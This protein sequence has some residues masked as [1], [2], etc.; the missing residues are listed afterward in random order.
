[1]NSTSAIDNVKLKWFYGICFGFLAMLC[2]GIM[3]ENYWIAALPLILG[4]VYLSVF[5]ID[6]LMFIVVFAT[7]LAINL[8]E[9]GFGT[10]LSVPSEPLM[11]G[12]M[13]LFLLKIMFEGGFDRRVLY[14]PV[15]IAIIINLLWIFITSL[16]STMIIVSLKHLMA[17]CWFV[18]TFYFLGTQLFREYKNI[19]RFIWVYVIP[20]IIVIGYTIIRHAGFSFTETTAHW[21][22]YPFYNDH[23]AYAAAIAMF[24]PVMIGLTRN[25]NYSLNKRM[26]SLLVCF[27][28]TIAIVLSYTRAAWISLA[29]ALIVYL[30]F[31]F[32]I[33]FITVFISFTGLLILFF[34]FRSQV[35]MK[36]EKNRHHSSTDFNSHLQSISN[37]TTDASNLERINRWNSALRMFEQKPFFGWGPGTYQFKYA[38]YQHSDEMTII[39][40][41]A[42]DRGNSHSEYIGPLAESGV[43]GAL[44]F[45]LIVVVVI[46]RGSM[47]Y[48]RSKDKE[49]RLITLG[50]VL[51]LVTYFVHGALNNF[52]DTDKASVP[53]WGFIGILTA[54]D[55]YHSKRQQDARTNGE[56]N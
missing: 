16:T 53:F 29:V 27:I 42:G 6:A 30:I 2:I 31:A 12:I 15:T 37:I 9:K 34:A 52:L 22:M 38:P 50:I 36:L 23:T 48:I 40:T 21:V 47:L 13:I 56:Q 3:K 14:H 10:S 41:N 35:T 5:G 45:V 8:N 17:R 46:Y 55:V 39:S 7:P 18:I 26:A 1:M 25:R 24:F 54:M 51:G 4:I 20:L 44:T 32:R 33:R 11:F 19:K 43:L 49:I 28:F